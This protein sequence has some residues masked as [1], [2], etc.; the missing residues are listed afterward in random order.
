MDQENSKERS[1]GKT[2]HYI[3]TSSQTFSCA[4]ALAYDLKVLNRAIII[5]ENS[6]GGAKPGGQMRLNNH[7][8]LFVPIAKSENPISKNNWETVGVVPDVKVNGHLTNF[9]A[10]DMAA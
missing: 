6:R 2:A 5:G 7:F 3:L 1:F 9:Q 10:L 4:E 8:S